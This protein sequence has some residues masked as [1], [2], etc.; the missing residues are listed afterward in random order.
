MMRLKELIERAKKRGKKFT[1]LGVGPVSETT[2]R[3]TMNLAKRWNC[4]PMLIA[5]RNQ[6]DGLSFGGGYLMGGM[7]Q[8]RFVELI[9]KFQA[10]A[11]YEGPLYIC[12][13]HGGP[14][15]RDEELRNRYPAARAMDL[16][17]RSFEEDLRAGFNYLHVDPTKCPFAFTPED[18]CTWTVELIEHCEQ[19]RCSLGLAPVDYEI[20]AEDI[21][22]GITSERD[23][24]SF[25][26]TISK[27][28]EQ[29]GL[30]Q[31]TSIVGQTGTLTRLDYNAGHFDRESTARL[32]G[33]AA[34]Y[35]V[36]FKEHNG[37]YLSAVS[38]R[39][40][41]E[42]G[43]T[44]MNVAPEF[45]L[46]ETDALLALEAQESKL[47]REGWIAPGQA[48]HLL[49]RLRELTFLEAPWEKWMTEEIRQLPREQV[50]QD[51]SLRLLI[52]RVCGHY[53]FSNDQVKENVEKLFDNV[54]RYK[55][56]P[57]SAADFVRQ[58]VETGIEFYIDNFAL[59][60]L[61]DVLA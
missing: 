44:G 37:D 53:L 19:I 51:S 34:R 27:K 12:R 24:E 50:A 18:L 9:R 48:S 2:V 33:I 7:D 32:A 55:L 6:V 38:C 58:R 13:D 21:R 47:V 17:R 20:G 22:G 3:A 31:P 57:Q 23:F 43:V 4:P 49:E 5:S 16:A 42:L 56:I 59:A 41:P 35:G 8:L 11:G 25:L 40:H 1:L 52:T 29:A 46:T 28:L 36:G 45:G 26:K 15:Q 61:N 14:W 60:G 54:D 10:G 39:A 30:P